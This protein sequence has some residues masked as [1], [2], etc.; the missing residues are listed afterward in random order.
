MSMTPDEI[1]TE[2]LRTRLVRAIFNVSSFW[3]VSP[4]QAAEILEALRAEVISVRKIGGHPWP[5]RNCAA[6]R[7][8]MPDDALRSLAY[9]GAAA[10]AGQGI[11][12]SQ[13]NVWAWCVQRGARKRQA[14]GLRIVQTVLSALSAGEVAAAVVRDVQGRQLDS[15]RRAPI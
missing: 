11:I 1:R 10:I 4:E 3:G 9:Q 14:V 2:R 8:G 13:R 6:Y 15:D 7:P 5:V 12:P